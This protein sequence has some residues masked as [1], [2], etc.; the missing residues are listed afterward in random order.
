MAWPFLINRHQAA[1]GESELS[2]QLFKGIRTVSIFLI[3]MGKVLDE[4]IA[5]DHSALKA[6]FPDIG[7]Q[8]VSVNPN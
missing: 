5:K 4:I 3:V 1:A 2:Q 6:C 8:D 7:G